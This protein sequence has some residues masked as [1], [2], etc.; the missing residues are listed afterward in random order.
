MPR[1]RTKRR[2]RAANHRTERLDFAQQAPTA[3]PEVV[4]GVKCKQAG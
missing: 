2:T 4:R 3:A 1:T